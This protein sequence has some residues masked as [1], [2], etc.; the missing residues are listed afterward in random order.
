MNNIINKPALCVT[1]FITLALMIIAS[2]TPAEAYC[3]KRKPNFGCCGRGS[4]N[5]FCCNCDPLSGPNASC[6]P[7]CERTNCNTSEWLSCFQ[8]VTACASACIVSRP[9]YTLCFTQIGKPLCEKCYAGSGA[10]ECEDGEAD[11][12][13]ARDN[14]FESIAN[15]DG[16]ST[17]MSRRDLKR[18]LRLEEERTGMVPNAPIQEIFDAYDTD[19][20]NRI[21]RNEFDVESDETAGFILVDPN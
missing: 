15:R 11:S 21:D 9:A 14:F 20:N 16:D 6:D 19:D 4:C 7:Q 10:T 3:C 8:A 13:I 2:S 12:A 17:T 18:F 5:I 1:A